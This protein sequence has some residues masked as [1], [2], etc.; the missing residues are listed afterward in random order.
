MGRHISITLAILLHSCIAHA[1]EIT[2]DPG[3]WPSP[4]VAKQHI[5][6]TVL[7][8]EQ[9]IDTVFIEDPTTGNMVLNIQKYPLAR[10]EYHAGMDPFPPIWRRIDIRQVETTD[11]VF[12]EDTRSGALEMVMH[13]VTK[14]IPNGAYHEFVPNGNIHVKG[15]LDG[16]NTDGTLKKT[17]EWTEWDDQGKVIRRETYR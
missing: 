4:D 16:Y 7:A 13:R 6:V 8:N 1:Q 3:N 9:R 15:T 10:Y 12:V 2:F 5:Q 17:G 11:T 14:D